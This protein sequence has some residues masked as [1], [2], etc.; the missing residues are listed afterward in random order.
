MFSG[1]DRCSGRRR[2]FSGGDGCPVEATNATAARRTD[3]QQ[4]RMFSGGN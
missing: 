1:G 4:R 2:M 3:I